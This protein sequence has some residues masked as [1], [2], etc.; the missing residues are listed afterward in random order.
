MNTRSD[1]TD[2]L[3][4]GLGAMGSAACRELAR[5]GH[6][7]TALDRY[8]PP[9]SRGSSAGGTR[10][11]RE[12]YFEEPL[13]VPLVRE[14]YRRWRELEAGTGRRL[15]QVTGGLVVGRR[16]GGLVSGALRS[17][18]VHGLEHQV[19]SASEVRD[20][21]PAFRLREEE[22]GVYEPRAGML[23][24]EECVRAFLEDAAR[25]G[26]RIC[27][28]E[29]VLDWTEEGEGVAVRTSRRTLSAGSL[30]LAGGPWTPA[31]APDL[32]FSLEVERNVQHWFRPRSGSEGLG[33]DRFPVFL[34]ERDGRTWYG[35][36][37]TGAG[38]KVAWH[39]GG[40]RCTP[41]SMRRD[42][43]PEEVEEMRRVLAE[44]L[45]PAAGP[46]LRSQACM[47]TNTRDGHFLIDRH[48]G[49][50]R[51]F[52]A[53]GFSG[54]GFKFAAVLGR[55]LADLATGR[56]PEFDLAPFRANRRREEGG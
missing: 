51:V 30:L 55:A 23:G 19:L 37:R 20:R 21:W 13:Y 12:A 48:P 49:T 25:S 54:H 5:R 38:M 17:A 39:H 32:G 41:E 42:A 2:V 33:P 15:L 26:A 34:W 36:P 4:V 31:L 3:V 28:G 8:H 27:T 7:V 50:S 11:I 47:Y 14:S 6:R 52:V 45:P 9:H 44:R 24:A 46:H 43:R 53:G 56:R 35:F 22:C 1:S 29:E 40:T 16:E 18:A 10:M